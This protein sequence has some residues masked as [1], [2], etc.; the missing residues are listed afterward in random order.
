MSVYSDWFLA[1]RPW[2]FTMTAVSVS[3]GAALAGVDG[4][5][6]WGLYA[7]TLFSAVCMHAAANLH[8]DYYD[9]TQG[10]DTEAAATAQ[11]RPHP[12]VCG[13]L[14]TTLVLRVAYAL[15]AIAAGIGVLLAFLSGW[16]VLLIGVAGLA[17][18][19]AYT[20]P[21]VKFK[22]LALGEIFVFLMWGPLMVEGAYYV[23]HGVFSREALLLSL[24]FGC[25]VALVLL[26]NNIRDFEHDRSRGI[27]TIA[28]LLGPRR[29]I[30]AY[31]ALI[32]AAYAAV[33]LLVLLGEATP[34]ALLV[35]VTVP[36]AAK[37]LRVM[38]NTLP[39]DAD[40]RTAKLDTAFGVLLVVSLLLEGLIG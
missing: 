34:W 27:T 20:A 9:V 28:G 6:S 5:F 22:Y 32:I 37:L 23:Q 40:A 15:F 11:Y 18:A 17:A 13:A 12:L 10:V 35:F 16:A 4:S 36:L 29:G 14:P 1:C 38:R 24:P 39:M 30:A 25:L 3:V 2:S 31:S 8:N 19:T 33:G 21:P 26:A 7:A